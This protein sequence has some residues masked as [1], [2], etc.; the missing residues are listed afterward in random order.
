M[1]NFTY[2]LF[3]TDVAILIVLLAGVLW[4]ISVPDKR[5]WPPPRRRSWQWV[6]TWTCYSAVCGLNVAILL[7]D[8]NAWRFPSSLRF[9][10]GIPLAL[11]GGL[12]AVWGIIALGGKNSAGLKDGFVLAGPYRFTEAAPSMYGLMLRLGFQSRFRRD[13]VLL[14]PRRL[15]YGGFT[16]SM[17][18]GAVHDLVLVNVADQSVRPAIYFYDRGRNLI[19]PESV[20]DVIGDLEATEYGVLTLQGGLHPLGEVT[21]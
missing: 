11:I 16:L 17:K 9:V 20:V 21:L 18:S 10:A 14:S 3:A 4:S 13:N 2:T 6:L 8:W 15:D 12:V 5:I 7:L 1:P 19:D